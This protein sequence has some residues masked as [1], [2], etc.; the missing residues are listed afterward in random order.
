[1][2]QD[3]DINSVD[4]Q[5]WL[6]RYTEV[7]AVDGHE[8]RINCPRPLCKND[9]FKLYINMD[10][11]KWICFRCGWG[12]GVRDVSYLMAEVSNRNVND[13]RKEISKF[14]IPS[15]KTE[16]FMEKLE[17]KLYKKKIKIKKTVYKSIDVPGTAN[18]NSVVYKAVVNYAISRGLSVS[19]IKALDLHAAG[20][21]RGNQGPFLVFPI[22]HDGQVV[23]YQGRRING[24]FEPKYVSG[25]D[26][27][28][29]L[30]PMD[31]IHLSIYFRSQY[32]VLVEG[33]FDALALWSIDIPALCTFGKK[34]SNTQVDLL[35]SMG[36][37]KL[38][39][40]WDPDAK[41]EIE[42]ASLRLRNIFNVHI[43]DLSID[44]DDSTKRD[45][46]K[47]LEDVSLK[48]WLKQ[49]IESAFSIKSPEFFR[50][51]LRR[52]LFEK[53]KHAR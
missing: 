52:K 4:L 3:N 1:M 18:A 13:I 46:G 38:V 5:V 34:I 15:L 8:F 45:P 50:W 39:I 28:D 20:I 35:K 7:K 40:A 41:K 12:K 26:I 32:A 31:Q 21:L 16:D 30:Y 23:N 19:E 22:V 36:I 53:G 48:P 42:D 24:D 33:I 17:E 6:E 10:K 27:H 51:Q 2:A 29:Y 11:Q 44:A 43:A 49:V 47:T 14:V 25:P 9:Q 37:E